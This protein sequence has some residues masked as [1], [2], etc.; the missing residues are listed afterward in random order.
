MPV[1]PPVRGFVNDYGEELD[2]QARHESWSG[3]DVTVDERLEQSSVDNIRSHVTA[4][5]PKPKACFELPI[6][7]GIQHELTL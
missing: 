2:V 7:G 1:T 5:N 6:R 4:L 3:H